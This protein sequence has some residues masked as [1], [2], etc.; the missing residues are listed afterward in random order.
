M[1][2]AGHKDRRKH[3][4]ISFIK[5][6][7]VPGVGNL[8]CSNLSEGGMFLETVFLYSVGT[9]LTLGFKLQETNEQPIN[10]QAR[11]VFA[12]EGIGVGLC[13]LNLKAEDRIKIEEFIEQTL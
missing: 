11:V 2:Y 12:Y 4:R 8:R 9:L 6:V 1:N 7:E 3:K 10:V 5:D 13:F